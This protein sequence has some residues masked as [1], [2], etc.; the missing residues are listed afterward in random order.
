RFS[1]YGGLV[2][3]LLSAV[4]VAPLL[5]ALGASL[6]AP[7][8]RRAFPLEWRLAADNLVRAPGR[9]GLVIAALAAGVALVVQTAGTIRSNR[10]ALREWVQAC[11]SSDLVIT[12]GSPVGASG[13]TQTMRA[14]LGRDIAQHKTLRDDVE[15]VLPLRLCKISFRDTEILINALDAAGI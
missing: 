10:I 9:T 13:Q 12:S 7:V 8:F 1:I 11:I 2:C 15:A 6:L 14:D 4:V 3:V 5:T